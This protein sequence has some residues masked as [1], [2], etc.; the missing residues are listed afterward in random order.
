M[1]VD[2]NTFHLSSL[3]L[4][5]G[6]RGG[7]VTHRDTP[8]DREH[9]RGK[10]QYNGGRGGR[11]ALGKP[12]DPNSPLERALRRLGDAIKERL[13]LNKGGGQIGAT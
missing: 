12:R 2:P 3:P 11:R 9:S 13:L 10:S 7:V 5:A 6:K 1:S 4:P 8:G